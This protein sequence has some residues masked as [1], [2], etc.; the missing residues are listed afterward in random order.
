MSYNNVIGRGRVFAR[1]DR[2]GSSTAS[3]HDSEPKAC[4]VGKGNPQYEH[5]STGNDPVTG[6]PPL[7]WGDYYPQNAG[8]DKRTMGKKKRKLA[9]L[10]GKIC[11][12]CKRVHGRD[13]KHMKLSKLLEHLSDPAEMDIFQEKRSRYIKLLT[14]KLRKSAREG[15][16]ASDSQES[17]GRKRKREERDDERLE[18]ALS[19]DEREKEKAHTFKRRRR[20]DKHRGEWV[21]VDVWKRENPD[22]PVPPTKKKKMK[23]GA[24]HDCVKQYAHNPDERMAFSEESDSGAEYKKQV[25]D[26]ELAVD[27][28]EALE[29]HC[30][31]VISFSSESVCDVRCFKVC[32]SLCT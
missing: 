18:D 28:N 7:F 31:F 8:G 10:K 13:Y 15:G 6:K 16:D 2:A 23:S 11:R 24:V 29:H 19:E 1:N 22:K 17:E 9:T 12:Y 14:S 3:K 30:P 21:R 5:K 20:S 26:S 25:A 27:D 32:L 4:V